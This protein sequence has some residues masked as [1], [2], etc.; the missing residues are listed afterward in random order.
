MIRYEHQSWEENEREHAEERRFTA[1]L[2]AS[3]EKTALEI[4]QENSPFPWTPRSKSTGLIFPSVSNAL[5]PEDAS[6]RHSPTLPT[7]RP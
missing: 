7:W 1:E 2:I 4:Q 6:P 3:G 5:M